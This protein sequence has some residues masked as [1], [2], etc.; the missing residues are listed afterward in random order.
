MKLRLIFTIPVLV[1]LVA[2]G[3]DTA[4]IHRSNRQLSSNDLYSQLT[5]K[6]LNYLKS[7]INK[8]FT[9]Q[10]DGSYIS[11]D[12][13]LLVKEILHKPT[14]KSP[15]WRRLLPGFV[16]I[17]NHCKQLKQ[18]AALQRACLTAYN[19]VSYETGLLY[20]QFAPTTYFNKS[21]GK[22]DLSQDSYYIQ[23]AT[24]P[25]KDYLAGAS[26]E[27]AKSAVTQLFD[28]ALRCSGCRLNM[29]LDQLDKDIGFVKG[30]PIYIDLSKLTYN[31][32]WR[33]Q[34]TRDELNQCLNVLH[35]WI[36][37]ARPELIPH[38]KTLVEE[39]N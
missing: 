27:D 6:E 35:N 30:R 23:R 14:R 2:L 15:K 5:S 31:R 3:M 28:F 37:K 24:T 9:I 25:S 20:Y 19:R 26:I 1:L 29:P 8:R 10:E 18:K 4:S 36:L 11:E 7:Q 38:Y 12:K 21:I 39:L 33:H 34:N 32:K 13:T 22:L 16:A 17:G